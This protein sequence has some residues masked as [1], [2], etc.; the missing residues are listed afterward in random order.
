MHPGDE[1]E[2]SDVPVRA[3]VPVSIDA[4]PA[5]AAD[6]GTELRDLR[7]HLRLC[8]GPHGV[9]IRDNHGSIVRSFYDADV[10]YAWVL[11]NHPDWRQHFRRRMLVQLFLLLYEHAHSINTKR[12][13]TISVIKLCTCK[14]VRKSVMS[15]QYGSNDH[16]VTTTISMRVF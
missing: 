15:V 13:Y 5:A 10:A 3:E 2:Q 8:R 1:E 9:T 11:D 6:I 7:N 4:P 16:T 14:A 12:I